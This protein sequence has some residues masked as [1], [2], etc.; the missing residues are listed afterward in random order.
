MKTPQIP[1]EDDE[2][3][4]Y[5]ASLE[6]TQRIAQVSNRLSQKIISVLQSM[7]LTS[8]EIIRRHAKAATILSSIL[9]PTY[10]APL[11]RCDLFFVW[12]V[13]LLT[14]D[15]LLSIPNMGERKIQKLY[16]KLGGLGFHRGQTTPADRGVRAK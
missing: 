10:A 13:L 9:P 8:A 11:N 15:E 1:L 2:D 16:A 14:R 5:S 7:G 6:K 12:Q 3:T 4:H